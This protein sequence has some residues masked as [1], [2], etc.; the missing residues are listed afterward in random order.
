MKEIALFS[1]SGCSGVTG[2]GLVRPI[3]EPRKMSVA[4]SDI[5]TYRADPNARNTECDMHV[6]RHLFLACKGGYKPSNLVGKPEN[7]LAR[8]TVGNAGSWNPMFFPF[9]ANPGGIGK[10]VYVEQAPRG[11]ARLKDSGNAYQG[12]CRTPEDR[13]SIGRRCGGRSAT[14]RPNGY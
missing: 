12:N 9:D 5:T 14:L 8:G 2:D 1:L 10:P 3:I 13:D 4:E 6:D 7:R 11:M